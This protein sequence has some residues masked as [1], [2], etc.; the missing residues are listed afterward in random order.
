MDKEEKGRRGEK[1]HVTHMRYQ[2]E[3]I[4]GFFRLQ[5]MEILIK[6]CF[7][8]KQRKVQNVLA[9]VTENCSG[10]LTLAMSD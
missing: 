8:Q 2:R 5:V 6:N 9:H 3:S 1:K 4:L 10:M 7:K